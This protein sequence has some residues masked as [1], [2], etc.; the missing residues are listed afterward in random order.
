MKFIVSKEIRKE[1]RKKNKSKITLLDEI[2]QDIHLF[3][4]LMFR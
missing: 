2:C 4:G 1:I 3:L